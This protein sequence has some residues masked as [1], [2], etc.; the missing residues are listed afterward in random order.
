MRAKIT[1][2]KQKNS[3]CHS[4]A[5]AQWLSLATSRQAVPLLGPI[6]VQEASLSPEEC[7]GERFGKVPLT[8]GRMAIHQTPL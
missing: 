4:N 5:S 7:Q 8:W 6:F 1:K 2:Q 3:I